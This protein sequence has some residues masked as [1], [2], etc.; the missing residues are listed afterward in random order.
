MTQQDTAVGR[1][2]AA[3][4]T[5]LQPHN[6]LVSTNIIADSIIKNAGVKRPCTLCYPDAKE[7]D[8]AVSQ[9]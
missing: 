8:I 7:F 1:Q 5:F 4:A 2:A 3:N 9:I 6:K